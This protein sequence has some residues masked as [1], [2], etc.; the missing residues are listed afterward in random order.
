G[1]PA[2]IG[3]QLADTRGQR[4]AR[5]LPRHRWS[6]GSY[7]RPA[8]SHPLEANGILQARFSSKAPLPSI[9][10]VGPMDNRDLEATLL[11]CIRHIRRA[12]RMG[13]DLFSIGARDLP[14][15]RL[16]APIGRTAYETARRISRP[17]L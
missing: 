4:L 13:R 3:T 12:A 6:G 5:A 1:G 2:S 9:L 7:L 10:R 17:S 11:V 8:S 14:R 16:A 15:A